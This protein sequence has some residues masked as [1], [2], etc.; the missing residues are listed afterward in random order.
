[1]PANVVA[2][3]ICGQK[4]VD[5]T[6]QASSGA[7]NYTAAA[8]DEKGNRLTCVSNQTSCRL[9]GITCDHVYYISVVAVDDFC[10]SMMSLPPKLAIGTKI[11]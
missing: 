1:M 5:V 3:R 4:F 7:K 9:A 6:W 8:V 2:S 10:T 11:T